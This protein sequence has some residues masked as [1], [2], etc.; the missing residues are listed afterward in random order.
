MNHIMK[1]NLISRFFSYNFRK[2][3]LKFILTEIEKVEIKLFKILESLPTEF[4]PEIEALFDMYRMCSFM[5]IFIGLLWLGGCINFIGYN[6]IKNSQIFNF[7]LSALLKNKNEIGR[8]SSIYEVLYTVNENVVFRKTNIFCE[9]N[10]KK[11][12]E[13]IENFGP[14]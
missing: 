1:L 7:Y 3:L 11:N 5:W 8:S 6:P 14:I 10:T 4:P 2:I 12:R 9:N 13:F